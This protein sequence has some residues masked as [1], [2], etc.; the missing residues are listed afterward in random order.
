LWSRKD[1]GGFPDIAELK[2]HVRDAI[3]PEKALGHVDRKA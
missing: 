1:E 2:R 3:A